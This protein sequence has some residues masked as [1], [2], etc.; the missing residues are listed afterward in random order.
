MSAKMAPELELFVVCG[1]GCLASEE[2]PKFGHVRPVL[3]MLA[4]YVLAHFQGKCPKRRQP[5]MS[6]PPKNTTRVAS[7]G[8]N[9]P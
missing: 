8:W 4:D 2:V 5:Q 9:A 7:K 6:K 3:A 1:W